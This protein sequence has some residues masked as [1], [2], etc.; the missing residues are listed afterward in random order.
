MTRSIVRWWTVDPDY[1]GTSTQAHEYDDG[2]DRTACGIRPSREADL[3]DA[4]SVVTCRRC[5][6]SIKRRVALEGTNEYRDGY[7]TRRAAVGRSARP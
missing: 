3:I 1:G 4:G 5:I 7:Q 6:A 2:Y